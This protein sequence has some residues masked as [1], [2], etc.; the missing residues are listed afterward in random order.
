MPCAAQ[1]QE[2]SGA[3]Q[4]GSTSLAVHLCLTAKQYRASDSPLAAYSGSAATLFAPFVS[5]F[6]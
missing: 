4:D 3:Q 6:C 1:E 2:G 5:G